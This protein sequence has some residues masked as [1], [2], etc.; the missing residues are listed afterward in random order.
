M[1][2]L[3][4]TSSDVMV[5]PNRHQL[6]TNTSSLVMWQPVTQLW[7]IISPLD[8]HSGPRFQQRFPWGSYGFDCE[9]HLDLFIYQ[10][11]TNSQVNLE[12]HSHRHV[13][14]CS[15][16]WLYAGTPFGIPGWSACVQVYGSTQCIPSYNYSLLWAWLSWPQKYACNLH[17]M[18][19]S[20]HVHEA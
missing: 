19:E 20:V 17:W 1:D 11:L 9:C 5:H 4:F 15:N 6:P 18:S 2:A 14:A 8:I 10:C 12:P 3:P 16:K 13:Q 7:P